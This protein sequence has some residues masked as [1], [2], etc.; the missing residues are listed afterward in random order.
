MINEMQLVKGN[1]EYSV[2]TNIVNKEVQTQMNGTCWKKNTRQN[3][4]TTCLNRRDFPIKM[5]L[6]TSVHPDNIYTNH[7]AEQTSYLETSKENAKSH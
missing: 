5:L 4:A 7:P 3:A 2:T 6:L 1:N